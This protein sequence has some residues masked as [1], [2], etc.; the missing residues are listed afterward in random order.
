VCQNQNSTG[1]SRVSIQPASTPVKVLRIDMS[2][3]TFLDSSGIGALVAI[4]NST[5]RDRQQLIL[6]NVSPRA[7]KVLVIT[8]LTHVLRIE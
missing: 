8:G 1:D 7:L 3:V 2:R 5:L 4:Q 6:E